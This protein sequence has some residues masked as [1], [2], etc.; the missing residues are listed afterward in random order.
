LSFYRFS[1][2]LYLDI[3]LSWPKELGVT[4]QDPEAIGR[5]ALRYALARRSLGSRVDRQF[6][7]DWAGCMGL[8]QVRQL[9]GGPEQVIDLVI[10]PKKKAGRSRHSLPPDAET[11]ACQY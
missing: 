3:C 9:V 6:A 7:R 11:G 10:F 5:E 2:E 4:A 1:Q 8:E